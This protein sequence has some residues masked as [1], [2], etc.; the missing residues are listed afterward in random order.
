MLPAVLLPLVFSPDALDWAGV[1]VPSSLDLVSKRLRGWPELGQAVA[2]LA[3]SGGD[4]PFLA[5]DRYQI[6]SQL[7]FYVPGHPTVY[8]ANFGRRMNQYDL[9]GGWETLIGRN[10]LFVLYGAVD[11]PDDLRHAFRTL[12]RVR[13]LTVW[14]RGRAL[15]TFSIFKGE[16]FRGFPSRPYAGF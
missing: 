11:P 15:H 14:H 3:S 9:W 5:S 7:A 12:E 2:Q 10:G 8:N 6:A 16:E 1:R 13:T 4:R